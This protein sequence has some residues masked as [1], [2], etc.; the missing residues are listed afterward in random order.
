[1]ALSLLELTDKSRLM[2]GIFWVLLTYGRF[3]Y[4][5]FF[6]LHP[7]HV[8]GKT[9]VETPAAGPSKENSIDVLGQALTLARQA[10]ANLHDIQNLHTA[11]NDLIKVEQLRRENALLR[12]T[13]SE[14][15]EMIKGTF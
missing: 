8:M 4:L 13:L 11:G 1:M 2:I 7:L 3:P 12:K 14:L 15:E 10:L 9:V 6:T 5:H